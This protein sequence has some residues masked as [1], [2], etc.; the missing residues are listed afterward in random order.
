MRKVTLLILF[1]AKHYLQ[2]N[3]KFNGKLY[4][5]GYERYAFNNVPETSKQ[6]MKIP[7][8][9]PY[10]SNPGGYSLLRSGIKISLCLI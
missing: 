7:S 8:N 5:Q 6:V 1:V 10:E 9:L 4:T 2:L 3:P